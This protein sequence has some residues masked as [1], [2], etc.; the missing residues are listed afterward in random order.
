MPSSTLSSSLHAAA[1]SL[2]SLASLP[3]STASTIMATPTPTLSKQQ[4]TS[5]LANS[6]K[7]GEDAP[8]PYRCYICPKAFHRL[9]HQTRHVRTHTGERPHQCTFTTCQKRF[10]RSDELTRHMRIHSG[11]SVK[12]SIARKERVASVTPPPPP[13]SSI[14][15][16]MKVVMD[17]LD[18]DS[19][20]ITPPATPSRSPSPQLPHSLL[21][22]MQRR[23]ATA[24]SRPM[25]YPMVT[26]RD[27]Y[28]RY[29][30]RQQQQ[31]QQ[32]Q[33]QISP[34]TSANSSPASMVMSDSE[35]DTGAS[36][37]FTP[38]SSPVPAHLHSRSNSSSISH[39]R[40]WSSSAPLM[41]EPRHH[42]LTAP[43]LAPL[44]PSPQPVTL[45]PIS[46]LLSS[47]LL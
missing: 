47:L 14:K 44:C 39:Q 40:D 19:T 20:V 43:I 8:R 25:P 37:L 24:T 12:P 16:F 9:E 13:A 7:S 26:K 5:A 6:A 23:N 35:S 4:R 46:S 3:D 34:A 18:G 27:L 1:N 33:Q 10:S 38:E 32:Q 21:K 22:T 42:G 2:L 11:A 17:E 36:P 45:P 31:Q 41:Y 29:Q 15:P 28:H 30:Q